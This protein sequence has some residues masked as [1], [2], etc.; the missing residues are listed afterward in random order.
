MSKV[1]LNARITPAGYHEVASADVMQN[2]NAV[3]LVDV[4]E[5]HEWNADLGHLAS[6]TLVPLSAWPGAAASI[7]KTRP[8]VCVCRSGQRSARAAAELVR[9]GH[10]EVYNLAGGMMAWNMAGLPVERS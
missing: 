1:F 6:A 9:A 2:L 7:E 3:Q 8:V 10:A 4:R 5:N